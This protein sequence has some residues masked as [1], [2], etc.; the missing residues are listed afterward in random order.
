MPANRKPLTISKPGLL[1]CEGEDEVNFFN[2][3]FFELN[4]TDVQSLRTK[5]RRNWR[6]SWPMS[7]S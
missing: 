1:L 6:R 5:E 4:I 7:S 2:A 3:W